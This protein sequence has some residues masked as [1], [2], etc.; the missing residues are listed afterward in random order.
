MNRDQIKGRLDQ[1]KGRVK[2]A[3]GKAMGH[4]EMRS[5][6]KAEQTTGKVQGQVGDA[7][8]TVKRKIDKL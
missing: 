8:E 4:R 3:A 1:M 7:K 5:E 6:G 2:E